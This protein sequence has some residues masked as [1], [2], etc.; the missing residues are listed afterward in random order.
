MNIKRFTAKNVYNYINIDIT[1][2]DNLSIITGMNGSGKTSAIKLMHAVLCPNFNDITN[3]PFDILELQLEH[4]EGLHTILIVKK[5]NELSIKVDSLKTILNFKKNELQEIE[6]INLNQKERGAD[7]NEFIFSKYISHP[8][9]N[10]IKSL[11]SPTFLGLDRKSDDF[12]NENEEYLY[13]RKRYLTLSKKNSYEKYKRQYKGS[14]G[15]SLVE[16]EMLIQQTYGRL[17]VIEDR[18][19]NALKD[20]ILLSSFEYTTFNHKYDTSNM[21]TDKRNLLSRRKEIKDSLVKIGYNENPKF[22]SKLDDFFSKLEILLKSVESEK[23]LSIEW[24]INQAQIE[25]LS[26]IV[27]VIDDYNSKVSERFKPLDKFLKTINSFF[28]DSKK[29]IIVDKIGQ[30]KVIN[31]NNERVSIDSLSSGEMQLI[32]LFANITLNRF[33]NTAE[34]TVLIIDEPEISLHIRWQERFI[35]LLLKSNKS[36][37]FILATHS[38]DIIGSYKNQCVKI[39]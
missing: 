10:F 20:E 4:K 37:Q 14:L 21:V 27:E 34:N 30:L 24:L 6:F 8:V 23:G 36:T 22:L 5:G 2:N 29:T 35:E 38:P 12:S 3:I 18:L 19:T 7:I 33:K 25:K 1:F 15:A 28:E 32:I 39:K 17:K 9:L 16:T 13:Q 31:P 11:P 26:R